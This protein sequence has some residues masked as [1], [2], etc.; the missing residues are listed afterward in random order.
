M[1]RAKSPASNA[2]RSSAPSPT[3]MALT[4]RPNAPPWPPPRRPGRCRRAWS[5][6]GREAGDLVKD[7]DLGERVLARGGVEHQ[8]T[9]CGA[10]GSS[11]L[12]TR[13]I[14]AS[15]AIRLALFCSRPAV[16]MR[17]RRRRSRPRPLQRL[18]GEAGRIGAA[19]LATTSAPARLPQIWS[20]SMAAA[21]KVSPA[22][23]MTV[24]PVAFN[25]GAP[26]CRWSW[27]CPCR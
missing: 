24:L 26:A 6:P 19:S 7:L 11:F 10:L 12:R 13:A 9:L 22:A 18:E 4:G 21:R 20:C 23:S 14:L 17:A 27:S 16:S 2:R 3:P 1:A 25:I 15:S 5:R 8:Q